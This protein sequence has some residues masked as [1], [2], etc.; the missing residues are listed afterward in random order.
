MTFSRRRNAWRT[1][2]REFDL[3]SRPL[4]MAVINV[5]PDSF[6]D[7]GRFNERESVIAEAESALEAGADIIDVGGESTRPGS[8]SVDEEEEISRVIPI[9]EDLAKRFDI[10]ISVDTNK[11]GVAARALDAGAEIIND[12][13][14]F[15]FDA[16]MAETVAS[17]SAGVVLMHSRGSFAEMH[18]I[19]PPDDVLADVARGLNESLSIAEDAGIEVRNICLDVGI[20][21]GKSLEQNLELIANL[22]RI[23]ELYKGFPMMI[24]TS[25][26][27]FIGRVLNEASVSERLYGTLAANAA[28]YV[29]G[30]NVFRVHDVRPHSEMLKVLEAITRRRLTDDP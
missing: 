25:R 3:G 4:L 20:G 2:S 23:V 6:S 29:R 28:A 5:T 21:F 22:D 18:R 12:I 27:S 16:R 19:E 26:K 30:A 14:G 8:S 1:S 7:G 10:A 13:S 9:V 11:S 17:R 24:G 15:R